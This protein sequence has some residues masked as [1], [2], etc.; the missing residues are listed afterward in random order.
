MNTKTAKK[1][2]RKNQ[3]RNI[4]NTLKKNNLK[5][6]KRKLS[7]IEKDNIKIKDFQDY[8]KIKDFQNYNSLLSKMVKCNIIHANKASRLISRK[9]K[10]IKKIIGQVMI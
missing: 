1:E 4:L 7:Q 6:I 9:S 3:K 10:K 8:T 2:F 5:K